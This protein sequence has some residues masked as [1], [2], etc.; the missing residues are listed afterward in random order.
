MLKTKYF[1][2]FLY[3]YITSFCLS[4]DPLLIT[5]QTSD[6]WQYLEPYTSY[7]YSE[8][9]TLT[10]DGILANPTAYEFRKLEGNIV[11]DEQFTDRWCWVKLEIENTSDF[12]SAWFID[13]GIEHIKLYKL[14]D[15]N[16]YH[17]HQS[18][19]SL[20]LKEKDIRQGNLNF[21]KINVPANI[22]T[23]YYIQIKGF[24]GNTI[25]KGKMIKAS[26]IE[27][28]FRESNYL[29]GVFMGVMLIILITNFILFW[30]SKD[31]TYLIY[32]AYVFFFSMGCLS[33][34][35][36]L[37]ELFFPN[38]TWI[39]NHN[40]LISCASLTLVFYAIFTNYYLQLKQ[41]SKLWYK[42]LTISAFSSLGIYGFLILLM[43]YGFHNKTK[44]IILFWTLIVFVLGNIPAIIQWRKKFKP[45]G[46][47]VFGN[48]ILVTG[49]FLFLLAKTGVDDNTFSIYYYLEFS[50][51]CQ[52]IIFSKGIGDRINIMRKESE[53]AQEKA[54]LQLETKVTE[55]T[56]ELNEQ[57]LLVEEQNQEIKDSITYAKRIQEAILPPTKLVKEWLPQSFIL[58]KPKDIVA[59]DFYWMESKKGWIY[60]AVAD[61]TGHG[62]PGAMVS[63]VCS[64][65][66]SVSVIDEGKIKPSEILNRTRELVI[67][68]FGRSE[69]Q[70]KD[71]MDISLCAL[72]Y[73]S[74]KMQW[75]GAN[76]SL[77]II[78]SGS[79]EIEAIRPDRQP[80][81]SHLQENLFKNHELQL[82]S[83][84]SV[85]LFS[86]GYPDQ[87][88]GEK[89]KKYKSAN[90]KRF[91]L[92][93]QDKDMEIQRKLLSEEFD[94]WKAGFEQ[95]DDVC[96]M[97]VRV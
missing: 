4:Q 3:V 80:I 40:I 30:S 59:G 52:V 87:F 71:G 85:Y 86:D 76:N 35:G 6:G 24:W 22:T 92:S 63:V 93:I 84:D 75:A 16:T 51:I 48:L 96:V 1:L 36:T 94:S 61:C 78:R 49:Q 64:N 5:D 34:K 58:Y 91:L 72:N 60:F 81:G 15:N 18:G 20:K 45:A 90:L 31:R 17:I 41:K 77:W 88:G 62:V 39:N 2:S 21:I 50:L 38:S 68:R 69:Q 44:L 14:S 9:D 57:K 32:S 27:E 70:I 26:P 74:G 53:E 10:I 65:A 23:T 7:Y 89:G 73:K 19:W 11:N 33:I 47:F 56:Q 43:F 97:G 28:K 12:S 66:L 29:M 13:Y 95:V 42:T 25:N 55:R 46:L 83:G 54:M 67:D 79:K 82:N 37:F 8:N